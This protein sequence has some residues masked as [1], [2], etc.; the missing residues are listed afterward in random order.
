[1]N[2]KLKEAKDKFNAW[3]EKHFGE[4]VTEEVTETTED[5]PVEETPAQ[6]EDKF[7]TV[8]LVDGETEVTVEPAIEVGAAIVIA[9]EDGTP[10]AAPAGEYELQ[11]GR[12]L[13]VEEDGIVAAVNMPAEEE[14]EEPMAEDTPNNAEKVK[15]VIERIEKEKIFEKQEET[16][17]TVKFLKEENEALKSELVDL[18]SFVKETFD[19][20]LSEPSKEP[21]QPQKQSIKQFRAEFGGSGDPLEKWLNKHEK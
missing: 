16:D 17:N 8:L 3:V 12:V 19:A 20:L 14:A 9:A 11:D 15:R 10:V 13:L 21:A 2:N 4:E 6:T 18:K 1:M 7:E 5:N